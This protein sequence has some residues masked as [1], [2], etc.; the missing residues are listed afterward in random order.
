[1]LFVNDGTGRHY[2]RMTF[3]DSKGATYGF[4]VGDLNGDGVPDLVVARSGAPSIVFFNR[5][6]KPGR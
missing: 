1:L 5:L 3:G 4:A 6:P 2:T